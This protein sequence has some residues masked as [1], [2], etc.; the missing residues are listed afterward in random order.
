T[1]ELLEK[2][3]LTLTATGRLQPK[4]GL[5]V[6]SLA[7]CFGLLLIAGRRCV[8]GVR[9]PQ[10]K[11]VGDQIKPVQETI[12]PNEP[13]AENLIGVLPTGVL[14]LAPNLM[15]LSA[16]LACRQIFALQ[17]E[18]L[19]NARIDEFFPGLRQR[20][21]ETLLTAVPQ[22]NLNVT[23]PISGGPAREFRVSLAPSRGA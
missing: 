17:E 23:V 3:N 18:N 10:E 15:V 12:T 5:F 11:V 20:A 2:S 14:I 7:I 19:S 4:R 16:N 9:P 6:G 1:R 21:V 8:Q 13:H 22:R